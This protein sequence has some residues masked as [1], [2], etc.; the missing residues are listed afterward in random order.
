MECV[1]VVGRQDKEGLNLFA[2]EG[3]EGS[4]FVGE[5]TDFDAL[6]G[7]GQSG[8]SSDIE[9]AGIVHIPQRQSVLARHLDHDDKRNQRHH[10]QWDR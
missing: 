5:S 10:P 4:L 1:W 8:V 2:F 6:V 7:I 3:G 9:N